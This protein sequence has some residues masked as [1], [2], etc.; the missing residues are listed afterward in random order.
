MP[1][2]GAVYSGPS[3]RP[4]IRKVRGDDRSRLFPEVSVC[5]LWVCDKTN[6]SGFD[7]SRTSR[8]RNPTGAPSKE[9][10][11]VQWLEGVA[12]YQCRYARARNSVERANIAY[13]TRFTKSRRLFNEHRNAER[14]RMGSTGRSHRKARTP[15]SVEIYNLSSASSVRMQHSPNDDIGCA[16][17]SAAEQDGDHP[18]LEPKNGNRR[19]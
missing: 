5:C 14:R 12:S 4:E 7:P 10:A 11:G 19:A 15:A 18:Y 2:G 3:P 8:S 17:E 13:Q 9:Q 16:E 1:D 6:L